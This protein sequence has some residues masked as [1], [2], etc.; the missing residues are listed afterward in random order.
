MPS[1]STAGSFLSKLRVVDNRHDNIQC[2]STPVFPSNK[3]KPKLEE[4]CQLQVEDSKVMLRFLVKREG[5]GTQ[6][7]LRT[8]N[9]SLQSTYTYFSIV[10]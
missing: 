4:H 1:C 5:W 7:L 3:I 6:G 2:K 8:T 10:G 9:L